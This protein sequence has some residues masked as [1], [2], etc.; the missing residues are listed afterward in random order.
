[1][2]LVPQARPLA[3]GAEPARGG[4][5]P[6]PVHVLAPLPYA[7]DALAPVIS[8][9][10]MRLHY[11]AHHAGYVRE[12]NRLV[13]GTRFAELSLVQV[14][15]SAAGIPEH[16]AIFRNAA[17]AWNHAFYWRSLS[18]APGA[19]PRALAERVDA[20]FGGLAPLKRELG[21]AALAQFGSGWAWLVLEGHKLKVV[22][23]DNAVT[24]LTEHVRPLLCID[25][26]EHAYYLDYHNRRADYVTAVLDRLVNWAF[27]AENAGLG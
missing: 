10:T 25:V 19:L 5:A 17:Q 15:Q 13:A 27:A 6:G 23:T 12:L 21:A 8:A 20:A 4:A 11:G 18:P 2:S 16:A 1:M 26:W 3:A 7:E 22:R 9:A 14:I 24:P